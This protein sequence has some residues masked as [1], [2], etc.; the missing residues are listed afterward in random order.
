MNKKLLKELVLGS[1]KNGELD[2]EFVTQIAEKLDRAQLKQY[3]NSLKQ[4][5]KLRN[6]YVESPFKLQKDLVKEF[7][8]KFP[9]KKI[10]SHENPSLLAGTKITH[11]DDI[12]EMNLKNS[13]EQIVDNIENYD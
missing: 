7:K 6:V 12:F 1:Y 9:D 13:L 10:M 2:N 3:I 11:N 5:E 8:T 4:A